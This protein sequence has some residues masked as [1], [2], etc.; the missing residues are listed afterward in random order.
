MK[1]GGNYL[2]VASVFSVKE[3]AEIEWLN[4]GCWRFEKTAE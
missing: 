4:R 2:W 1:K 3:A